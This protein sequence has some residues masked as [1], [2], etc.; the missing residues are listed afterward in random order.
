MRMLLSSSMVIVIFFAVFLPS[1]GCAG[2]RDVDPW[3]KIQETF[4]P[5][6]GDW[7]RQPAG[8]NEKQGDPW[9]AMRAIYLPWTRKDEQS[10]PTSAGQGTIRRYFKKKLFPYQNAILE[11]ASIFSIPH[12]IIEAV[13]MVES[14]GNPR[15]AAPHTTARGL[16]QTIKPTF[17]RARKALKQQGIIIDA[18]PFTPRA[19]IMAGSWYLRRMRAIDGPIEGSAANLDDW[20]PALQRY[21]AGPGNSSIG[22]PLTIIYADG[23]ST[24]INPRE[25]SR[26]VLSWARKL[27]PEANNQQG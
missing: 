12:Q 27:D 20:A 3:R 25:Y 7:Y 22:T 15:A 2:Q 9:A 8:H 21:Y 24:I 14:G 17:T 19:S 6:A 16:M 11:A 10:S 4:I 26:K 23:K 5:L 18:S 13:I 1:N